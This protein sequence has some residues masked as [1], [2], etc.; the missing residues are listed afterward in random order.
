MLIN[1][2]FAH[3][4]DEIIEQVVPLIDEII[5]SNS[6]NFT[7]FASGA[8]IILIALTLIFKSHSETVKKILFA[9]YVLAILPTTIYLSGATIYLNSVSAT[10]GPVHYHADFEIYNCGQK[11][12]L[13]DPEGLSNKIGT[14]VVHEHND[15]RIHIE[16]V[17]LD[18]HHLSIGHFFEKLGG[19]MSNNHLTV[20]TEQGLT[21]LKDGQVCPDARGAK[22]QVFVYQ[23]QGAIFTQKRLVDPVNYQIT[24][25]ANVPP[26]DCIIIEFD[27]VEKIKTDKIC[28]S[29]ATSLE[30]GKIY[31]Y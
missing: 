14:E 17:L 11:V 2:V 7:L 13:K 5:R 28:Q 6:I 27:P 21:T 19:S 12:E 15:N 3:G 24:K 4:E 31:G 9:L 22:A 20:P 30:R 29:Y 10:G 23:T 18:L 1:Q 26:G 8:V 16:G 25:Q